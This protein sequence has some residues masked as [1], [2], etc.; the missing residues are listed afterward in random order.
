MNEADP[1]ALRRRYRAAYFFFIKTFSDLYLSL[2]TFF[3][4]MR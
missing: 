2:C 3:L 4:L 1:V